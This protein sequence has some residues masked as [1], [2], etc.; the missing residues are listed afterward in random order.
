MTF[1]LEN[2]NKLVAKWAI[3]RKTDGENVT[4][5]YTHLNCAQESSQVL[6]SPKQRSD[7]TVCAR[8]INKQKLSSSTDRYTSE[9]LQTDKDT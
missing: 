1:D 5:R 4:F 9:E 2:P 8:A 7:E 3:Q 6:A